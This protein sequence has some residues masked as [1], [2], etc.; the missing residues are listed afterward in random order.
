MNN[1]ILQFYDSFRKFYKQFNADVP[2][3]GNENLHNEVHS[4]LED[5]GKISRLLDLG[6]FEKASERLEKINSK[7]MILFTKVPT[8]KYSTEV[9]AMYFNSHNKIQTCMYYQDN[10]ELAEGRYKTVDILTEAK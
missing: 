9:A 6:I 5:I 3:K 1:N 8:N 10:L 2:I 4:F 7:L